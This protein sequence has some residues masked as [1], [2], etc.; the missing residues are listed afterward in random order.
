VMKWLVENRNGVVKPSVIFSAV[1]GGRLEVVQ[2]CWKNCDSSVSMRGRT[3]YMQ[4]CLFFILI[5]YKDW[6]SPLAL[7]AI[8]NGHLEGI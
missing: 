7:S 6:V 1:S 3:T 5:V 8:P 2:W 4:S